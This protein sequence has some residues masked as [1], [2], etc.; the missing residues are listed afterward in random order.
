MFAIVAVAVASQHAAPVPELSPDEQA[1][2]TS[3]LRAVMAHYLDGSHRERPAVFY[4]RAS[5][6]PPGFTDQFSDF[7]VPLITDGRL[8]VRGENLWH[9][10]A[11]D[12]KRVP[13]AM[14]II[15]KI[16]QIDE[17]HAEV[18]VTHTYNWNGC[19]RRS[20]LERRSGEWVVTNYGG[21]EAMCF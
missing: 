8:L 20:L 21:C 14:V 19:R 4:V 17:D 12:G 10:V 15:S 13:C 3:V 18:R 11:I 16:T 2:V 6:T 7:G 9:N 5:G 1:Q